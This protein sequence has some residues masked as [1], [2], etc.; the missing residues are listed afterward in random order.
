MFRN[1]PRRLRAFNQSIATHYQKSGLTVNARLRYGLTIQG[2]LSTGRTTTDNCSVVSQVPESLFG[3]SSFGVTNTN[4]W[5]PA[6]Y[7]RL[8]TPFP[9]QVKLLGAYTVPRVDLQFSGTFQ[10][11]LRVSG[12]RPTFSTTGLQ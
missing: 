2:G 1:G 5:L 11:C 10:S 6:Q 8:E 9:S 4:V 3:T 7:C 12:S